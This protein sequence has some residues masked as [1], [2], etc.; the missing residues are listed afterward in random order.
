M[1]FSQRLPLSMADAPR[2]PPVLRLVSRAPSAQ[3]AS[4]ERRALEALAGGD[5]AALG[6]LYDAHHEAVR[7]FAVRFLGDASVAEDLVH[8]VFLALPAAAPRYRGESSLRTFLVAMA[9]N[10][11]RN[12][13]RAAMR[14]RALATRAGSEPREAPPRPDESWERA[15]LATRLQRALD[16]LSLEHRVA[17]VLCEVEERSGPEVARMLGVPEAT[18]RTRLFHAKR[19]LRELL[20]GSA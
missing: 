1:L 15:E 14:R 9:A 18:V 10:L 16:E 11:S 8:D 4:D 19:R 20:G 13:V 7:A 5:L 6:E 3:D 2:D 12:H 17:F